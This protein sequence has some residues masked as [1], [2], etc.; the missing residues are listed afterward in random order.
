MQGAKP[1]FA[2]I[3]P[4][5]GNICPLSIRKKITAKTKAI[6]PVHWGGTPCDMDEINLL[7]REFSLV[8]IEDA[9]HALGASY[10]NV[11]VGAISDFTVFSFQAVKHLTTG[12][13]GAVSC[14][15]AFHEKELLKRRW[16]NIDR[17]HT[18]LSLVGER[19]YRAEHVGYK[20]HM[21]NI[22]AAIGLGN[23]GFFQDTLKRHQE[24]G[25]FYRKNLKGV[26]GITLLQEPQDRQSSYWT[27]TLLVDERKKFVTSLRDQGIP[28]SV[29]NQRIDRN[30]VFGG[31]TPD[32]PGQELF[33]Q[34]QIS[35]PIHNGLKNS[36]LENIIKAIQ[37]GW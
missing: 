33:E 2:D 31:V 4:F 29:V 20:Y 8:V 24:I 35:L 34:K 21:N 32:L 15:T 26:R 13:G 10:K 16:F 14:L 6:L 22:A 9:A 37:K 12:D 11:P 5:S 30:P 28:T 19:I 25:E 1:V 27:F 18:V 3:Q 23:L 36:D 17:D 7:A